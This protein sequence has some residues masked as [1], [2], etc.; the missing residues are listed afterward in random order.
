[1]T[2]EKNNKV[3]KIDESMKDRYAA[4]GYDIKDDEGNVILYGKGKTVSYEEHQRVLK[5]LE[6]L[7]GKV[8]EDD[9][10]A[11]MSVDELKA[12]AEEHGINIGNASTAAGIAKKI[13]EVSQKNP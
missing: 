7:K 4:D 5:E 13:H 6:S 2:A 11:D 3:Y 12:Y 9:K 8:S 1:M 10:F